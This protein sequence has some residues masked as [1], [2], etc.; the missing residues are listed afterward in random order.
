[1]TNDKFGRAIVA[2]LRAM[3]DAMEASLPSNDK[4]GAGDG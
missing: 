1:M 4:D 3:A 2:G